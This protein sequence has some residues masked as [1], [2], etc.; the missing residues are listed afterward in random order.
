MK[1][2]MLVMLFAIMMVGCRERLPPKYR[3]GDMVR[4]VLDNRPGMIVRLYPQNKIRY[5]VRFVANEQKT[6]SRVLSADGAI[7]NSP[8]SIVVMREYEL[9]PYDKINKGD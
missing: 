1:K 6:D 3:C 4:S 7:V 9:K 5:S 2:V 8:Y